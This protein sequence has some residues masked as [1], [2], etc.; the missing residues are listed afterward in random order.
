MTLEALHY[1]DTIV[2]A[3]SFSAAARRLGLTPRALSRSI[4]K[5]ETYFGADLFHRSSQGTAL[6]AFGETVFPRV[7]Q[8]LEL[9]DHVEKDAEALTAGEPMV[10]R[11]G[12][13]PQIDMSIVARLRET[14]HGPEASGPRRGLTVLEAELDPLE[15][16]LHCDDVDMLLVP[17]LGAFPECRHRLI[18]SDYLVLSGSPGDV[19]PGSE[20][21]G[22]SVTVK[23][24]SQRELI[25]SRHG[26][27]IT[28]AVREILDEEGCA[29]AVAD[30]EVSNCSTLPGWA[31]TGMGSVVL[32][33]RNV[34]PGRSVQRITREDGTFVEVFYEAVW[35]PEVR[36]SE[37][38]EALAE[39]LASVML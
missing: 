21:D 18:D 34:P 15:R 17:A 39:T 3:G 4:A 22:A 23:Q 27:G 31:V 28:R 36:D 6:T 12:V 33:E 25:L 7:S 35:N 14:V 11:A 10:V 2:A 32:P 13:S 20:N 38:L 29:L 37:Y 30:V 9:L 19:P 8:F 26:C 24:L 5:L 1:V 16:A